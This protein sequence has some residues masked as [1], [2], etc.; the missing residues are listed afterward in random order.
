MGLKPFTGGTSCKPRQLTLIASRGVCWA[1]SSRCCPPSST[2]SCSPAGSARWGI[3]PGR[4]LR[5]VGRRCSTAHRVEH[6][7]HELVWCDRGARGSGGLWV[8]RGHGGAP[9]CRS[10]EGVIEALHLA[11]RLQ[12]AVQRDFSAAAAEYWATRLGR[13]GGMVVGPRVPRLVVTVGDGRQTGGGADRDAEVVVQV[14]VAAA[15]HPALAHAAEV[16]DRRGRDLR[17]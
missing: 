7:L 3:A 9:A 16:D 13:D 1:S 12:S 15:R 17:E 4:L 2:P 11:R 6:R 5:G 14:P 8:G 10:L